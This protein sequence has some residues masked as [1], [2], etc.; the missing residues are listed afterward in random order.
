[1]ERTN[2]NLN[3]EINKNQYHDSLKHNINSHK[4]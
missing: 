2:I 3:V 1:M 4:L